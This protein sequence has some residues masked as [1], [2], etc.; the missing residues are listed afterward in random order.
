MRDSILI[1]KNSVSSNWQLGSPPP[2]GTSFIL[3]GWYLPPTFV[4]GGMPETVT[5]I[6]ARAI[7]SA[8]QVIFMSSDVKGG[9][10]NE[11]KSLGEESVYV[12][13]EPNPLKSF[14]AALSS[15]VSDIVFL[16][17]RR[18]EKVLPLFDDGIYS[19]WMQGQV[20]LLCE[21]DQSL[22]KINWQMTLS[23]FEENWMQNAQHLQSVGV[24]GIMRPGVDGCVA[25]V[26]F[27]TDDFRHK[28]LGILENQSRA[29]GFDWKLLSEADFASSLSD[30]QT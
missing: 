4:D 9:V 23:L 22:P 1:C 21:P 13:E 24:R 20:V 6:L 2:F 12:L 11:W 19:W 28:F 17:T 14:W 30:S 7:T 25:G 15:R 18:P 3:I 8:A 29:S 26:L 27:L 16:S 10:A 5:E